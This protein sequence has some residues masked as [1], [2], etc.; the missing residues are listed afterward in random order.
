MNAVL[1][2]LVVFLADILFNYVLA[3]FELLC[4]VVT[5]ALIE[6]P[7]LIVSIPCL[8]VEKNERLED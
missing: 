8:C 5:I 6:Y 3:D 7:S 4:E 2:R 1:S